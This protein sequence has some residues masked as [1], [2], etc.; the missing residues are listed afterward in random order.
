MAVEFGTPLFTSMLRGRV[1]YGGESLGSEPWQTEFS[2]I[3]F[4]N[5]AYKNE[6]L[7]YRQDIAKRFQGG[8]SYSFN[9]VYDRP[10]QIYNPAMQKLQS[11][12]NRNTWRSWRTMGLTG[13]LVPWEKHGWQFPIDWGH[14]KAKNDLGPFKPGRRGIYAREILK[15]DSDEYLKPQEGGVIV[16]ESGH[17]LMENNRATLAWIAGPAPQPGGD[18]ASFTAKDH[19]FKPG[20]SITKS[21]VLIN[22]TRAAQPYTVQWTA[23]L[24]GANITT[25][26]KSGTLAIS[27]TLFVPIAFTRTNTVAGGKADGEIRMTATIGTVKHEDSFTFEYSHRRHPGAAPLSRSTPQGKRPDCCRAWATPSRCGTGRRAMHCWSSG[28]RRSPT[29]ASCPATSKPL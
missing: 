28:A 6:P 14:T 21:A 24:G 23:T 25:G 27:Q 17:V 12:F 26:N 8:Q 4:G 9:W 15:R 3:Y 16:H 11:L 19:S 20:E 1:A 7:N 2:A 18:N 5:E 29:A 22:D 13:G 10:M